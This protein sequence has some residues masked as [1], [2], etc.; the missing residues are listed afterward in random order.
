MVT[1]GSNKQSTQSNE[2]KETR[3]EPLHNINDSENNNSPLI[4]LSN[5]ESNEIEIN[6][7]KLSKEINCNKSSNKE[8]E[9]K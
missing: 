8:E 9:K 5:N 1:E 4:S 3:I 2:D 6:C 7:D